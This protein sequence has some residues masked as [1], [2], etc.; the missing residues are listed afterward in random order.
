MFALTAGRAIDSLPVD[1]RH[2]LLFY[3]STDSGMSAFLELA[4][5]YA[6]TDGTGAAVC[7]VWEYLKQRVPSDKLRTLTQPWS[8][9]LDAWKRE[10][11][12]MGRKDAVVQGKDLSPGQIF[13]DRHACS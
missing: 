5:E 8:I 6:G 1:R 9:E 7:G 3:A 10:W 12:D 11:A 4:S 2:K 13:S